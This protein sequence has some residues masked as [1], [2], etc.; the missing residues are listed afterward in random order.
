MLRVN[1]TPGPQFREDM[2]SVLGSGVFNADGAV[3]KY[4]RPVYT[5]TWQ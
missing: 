4:V 3:W 2:A 5:E 1:T